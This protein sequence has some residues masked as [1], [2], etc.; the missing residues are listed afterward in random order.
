[1]TAEEAAGV[2]ARS[3]THPRRAGD[4]LP[5]SYVNFYIANR[6]VVMPMYDKRLDGGRRCAR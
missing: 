1:M 6:Y 4:R 2:D 3:G 5:A